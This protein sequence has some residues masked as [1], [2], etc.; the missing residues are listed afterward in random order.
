[1]IFGIA[2]RE[3]V[4]KAMRRELRAMVITL[5]IFVGQLMK[6]RRRR[7]SVCRLSVVIKSDSESL[8]IISERY[9][10]GPQHAHN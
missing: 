9:G 8:G 6:T 5:A 10:L 1:M 2:E 3:T 7:C 4:H